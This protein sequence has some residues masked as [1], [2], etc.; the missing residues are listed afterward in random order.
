MVTLACDL[1]VFAP[2]VPTNLAAIFL[3]RRYFTEARDMRAP[4]LLLIC[5]SFFLLFGFHLSFSRS[6]NSYR[7]NMHCIR[8]SKR[9][10]R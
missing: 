5:H 3:A 10:A 4:S 6:K 7:I 8:F 2:G 9:G 1:D